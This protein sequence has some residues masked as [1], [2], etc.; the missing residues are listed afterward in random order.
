MEVLFSAYLNPRLYY[1]RNL[2]ITN[3]PDKIAK[4]LISTDDPEIERELTILSYHDEELL[5]CWHFPP[6]CALSPDLE[7]VLD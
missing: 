2:A 4:F 6:G 5:E 1:E 3:D 7:L